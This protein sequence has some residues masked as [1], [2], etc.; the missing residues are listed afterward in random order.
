MCLPAVFTYVL[1]AVLYGRVTI[2][3]GLFTDEDC[4]DAYYSRRI[5]VYTKDN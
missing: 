1:Y 2:G 5:I 4:E 3:L